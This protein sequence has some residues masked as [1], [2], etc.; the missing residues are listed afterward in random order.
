MYGTSIAILDSWSEVDQHREKELSA[1]VCRPDT[2]VNRHRHHHLQFMLPWS[3]SSAVRMWSSECEAKV[4][5]DTVHSVPFWLLSQVII[6]SH[7]TVLQNTNLQCVF[8][9]GNTLNWFSDMSF[10]NICFTKNRSSR[11]QRTSK[12]KKLNAYDD[13]L[14]VQFCGLGHIAFSRASHE[15]HFESEH[16]DIFE[17]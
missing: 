10:G 8:R 7:D 9:S 15:R 16:A 1:M 17:R 11:V 6:A 5:W 4:S 13:V 2:I 12:I 14:M 3:K